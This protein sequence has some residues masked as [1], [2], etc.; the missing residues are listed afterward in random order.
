MKRRPASTSESEPKGNS[1]TIKGL[2]VF[3]S[4]KQN[5]EESAYGREQL[6]PGN[7]SFI[8]D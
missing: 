8:L 6:Y 4:L 3:V 5:R 7:L 2:P 1:C